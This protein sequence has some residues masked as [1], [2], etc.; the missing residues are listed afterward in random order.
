M[1]SRSFLTDCLW[2]QVWRERLGG[3]AADC[4]A[5]RYDQAEASLIA[6]ADEVLA[7]PEIAARLSKTD[8]GSMSVSSN[9]V[10]GR[11]ALGVVAASLA[12]RACFLYME[13]RYADAH[14]MLNQ[15][16]RLATCCLLLA[17]CCLLRATCC[18]LLNG[19]LVST[20]LAL[21]RNLLI[22]IRCSS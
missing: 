14:D 4:N 20:L 13:A 5:Q 15:V 9:E 21:N 19:Q 11:R 6:L 7:H 1:V 16:R 22:S 10:V 17:A 18:V 2:L 12:G 8:A 3:V